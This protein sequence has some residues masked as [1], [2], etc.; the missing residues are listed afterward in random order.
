MTANRKRYLLHPGQRRAFAATARFILLLA[1]SQSGKTFFGPHWLLR[2]IKT[3][4]PGHYLI[5]CPSYALL[6]KK[7]L[8]EFLRLFKTDLRLGDYAGGEKH[9]FTFSPAGLR[10]LFGTESAD[11]TKVFFGHAA[12]PDSLESATYK[13][14]WLDEAG[15]SRFK[16]GSWEAILRRLSIHQ[17]RVL[18]TTTPYNLGWLKQQV[19]DRAKAGDPDFALI[20]FDSIENPYFPLAEYERARRSLPSWKFNM[21]YR[22]MF[23][24]PAGAIFDCFDESVH[25]V[26]RFAIPDEWRRFIGLD[27]GGLNTAACF[28]AKN[29]DADEYFMYREYWPQVNRIAADHV[30]A[31]RA[32]E[33]ARMPFCVGGAKSEGHWRDQFRADGLLVR[34]PAITGPDSV[35][36]GIQRLYAMFKTR[37]LFIFD[38]CVRTRDQITSY[39][40]VTDDLGNVGEAIEEKETWHLIDAMRYLSTHVNNGPSIGARGI[41]V[42]TKTHVAAMPRGV[43]NV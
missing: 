43:F 7:A 8:P 35:E 42:G 40:R 31:I 39:S 32:G 9:E 28:W 16:L 36:V 26:P 12:D 23:E 34:E 41:V 15:Q 13:A 4:G 24:R 25:V 21:F 11:E 19:H 14:A 17:G 1:G 37:R 33:P 10:H 30:R 2:E 5:A 18:I 3:R 27:F 22:G 29:P 38:D 20:Q 6:S